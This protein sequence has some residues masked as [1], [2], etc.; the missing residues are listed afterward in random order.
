MF[1]PFAH[2]VACYCVLLEVVAQRL[3]PV[4]LLATCMYKWTQQLPTML[5]VVGQN[6]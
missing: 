4:K 1:C 2:P 5:G 6:F 3:K